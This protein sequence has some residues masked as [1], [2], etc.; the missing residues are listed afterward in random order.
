VNPSQSDMVLRLKSNRTTGYGWYLKTYDHN[1][2][3]L[4]SYRYIA[5]NAQLAGAPGVEE[6]HFK[7]LST[8]NI[9]PQLSQITFSYMRPWE[10][11]DAKETVINWVSSVS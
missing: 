6:W 4:K 8:A 11:S 5:P 1:L 10:L 3:S 7:V 2:L 9:A